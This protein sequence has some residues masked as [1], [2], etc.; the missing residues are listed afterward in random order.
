[1]RYTNLWTERLTENGIQED[2]I[3]EDNRQAINCLLYQH[4]PPVYRPPLIRCPHSSCQWSDYWMNCQWK[5]WIHR[6]NKHQRLE[7]S[8]QLAYALR[9]SQFM[10]L[11][12]TDNRKEEAEGEGAGQSKHSFFLSCSFEDSLSSSICPWTFVTLYKRRP[13]T[14]EREATTTDENVLRSPWFKARL[15]RPSTWKIW[16]EKNKT[17]NLLFLVSSVASQCFVTS[18]KCP[19]RRFHPPSVSF[20]SWDHCQEVEVK[21]KDLKW[22]YDCFKSPFVACPWDVFLNLQYF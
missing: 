7:T 17:S 16:R 13:Q 5:Q 18:I 10:W 22:K 2:C 1:M 12:T 19:N 20:H 3:Q 9:E 21:V 15:R 14:R 11:Q 4:F 6:E 8:K